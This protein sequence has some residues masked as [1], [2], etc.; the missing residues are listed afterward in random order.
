MRDKPS[1][2]LTEEAF[3]DALIGLGSPQTEAH[4]AECADCRDR[5][6]EFRSQIDLF[7]QTSL[8]WSEARPAKPVLIEEPRPRLSLV[9]YAPWGWVL[10]ALLFLVIGVPVWQHTRHPIT[11]LGSA[12]VPQDSEEQI[13]QDNNLMRSVDAALNETEASPL[14]EYNFTGRSHPRLK[15]RSEVRQ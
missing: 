1:T 13:A 5:L 6:Q 12:S 7:N 11:N 2:H 9:P 14:R 10:A 15:Q 4:L 8:A 3:D